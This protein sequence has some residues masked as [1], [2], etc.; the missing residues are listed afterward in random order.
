MPGGMPGGMPG[1]CGPQG[2]GGGAMQ[3]LSQ[4]KKFQKTLKPPPSERDKC[5]SEWCIQPRIR[6]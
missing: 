4:M 1:Q 2:G 3:A 6:R 5:R